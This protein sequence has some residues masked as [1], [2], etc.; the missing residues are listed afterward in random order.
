[1]ADVIAQLADGTE[2]HFPEGTDPS[3][4]QATVKKQIGQVAAPQSPAD[5]FRAASIKAAGGQQSD[6]DQYNKDNSFTG[7]MNTT[8][9]NAR[10]FSIPA[11]AEVAGTAASMT[12]G[13]LI[14]KA[15]VGGTAG[16]ATYVG[17]DS[18]LQKLSGHEPD[19]GDSATQLGI[20]EIGNQTV[21][22]FMRGAKGVLPYAKQALG[23]LEPTFSQLTDSKLGKFVEDVFAPSQKAGAIT[24]SA[25]LS[26]DELL[27]AS[28]KLSG[29]ATSTLEDPQYHSSV[30]TTNHLSNAL[31]STF[32]E[33]DKQ[34]TAAKLIA[35][36]NPQTVITQPAQQIGP[37]QI[38][39]QTKTV[40]G[41][42]ALSSTLEKANQIIED[43]KG[44][45]LGPTNEQKPLIN[46]AYKL[47]G[48]TNAKFDPKSGKLISADPLGFEEAWNQ[49]QAFDSQG[50]WNKSRNDIT[51]TDNQFRGFSKSLNEDIDDSIANWQ[52]DPN[53]LAAK[54]WANS[55]AT[56]AQRNQIFFNP[57]TSRTLGD[58]IQSSDSTM[59]SVTDIIKDPN[60]LQR[61]LNAGNI[62][63]P[64]GTVNSSNIK[65]D[66]G[67]YNLM[68]T[69]EDAKAID[70][71][72][73]GK[74]SI[75]AKQLQTAWNDPKFTESKKLL[76]NSQQRA[77][78]DQLFKNIA[79]TQ[80]KQ[81]VV[82]SYLSKVWL[83]RAGMTIAP[84]LLTGYLTGSVEHAAGVAGVELGAM[85]LAKIMTNPK[86]ARF[87]VSAAA[88]QPLNA[89]EQTVAR[90]LV[91]AIQ[92]VTI[93]LKGQDGTDQK[94]SFDRDGHWTA[95]DPSEGK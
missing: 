41:P 73:P 44:L 39:A 27:A 95:D 76:Y 42:I 26:R 81:N 14:P 11:A 22:A 35:K 56:V 21:Q 23:K 52:N 37:L 58:I 2:L 17:L 62:K 71:K 48:S 50:G 87:L 77:D 4:I 53:K 67:A 5:K 60:K 84:S 72:N 80:E 91:S 61:A 15:I 31:D 49:K 66:L 89:S 54:A 88:G 43:S 93:S 74:L 40:E 69:F 9:Q 19:L 12:P 32:Q 20:N 83:A 7:Q 6:I 45:V 57:D 63:F 38:P 16:A 24:N 8:L 70:P 3:V 13:G 51:H 10:P 34:A 68:R 65:G 85:G 18:L 25:G 30:I 90:T 59:P 47:V 36:S 1:M 79:F 86:A 33:A 75:D 28:K 94:G 82:G 64:S 78:Y 46:E 92:G 29:R 55:K